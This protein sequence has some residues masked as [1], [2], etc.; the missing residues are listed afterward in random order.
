M[1]EIEDEK[2]KQISKA[3]KELEDTLSTSE[4]KITEIKEKIKQRRRELG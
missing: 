1:T 4:N 3:L 2:I